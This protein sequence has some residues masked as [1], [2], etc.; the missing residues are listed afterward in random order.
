MV[1]P[2]IY[3]RHT[4]SHFYILD[5]GNRKREGQP[6]YYPKYA[7]TWVPVSSC[8]RLAIRLFEMCP[9]NEV[10]FMPRNLTPSC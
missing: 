10:I 3:I 5:N 4:K 1:I 2:N 9:A 8:M 6:L 7:A